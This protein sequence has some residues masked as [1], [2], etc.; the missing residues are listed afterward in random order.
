MRRSVPWLVHV[1]V[2]LGLGLGFYLAFRSLDVPILAWMGRIG[3][4]ETMRVKTLPLVAQ[5]PHFVNDSLVDGLAAYALGAALSLIWLTDKER[6]RWLLFGYVVALG[7]EFVQWP[8]AVPGIF[9]WTDVVAIVLFYPLGAI[10]A[11][12]SATSWTLRMLPS[13]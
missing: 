12:N 8:G 1:G 3:G 13:G 6:R 5:L 11:S 4:V 7:F 2:P 9:G 10:L